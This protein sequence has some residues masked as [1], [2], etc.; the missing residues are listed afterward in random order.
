M[1]VVD[2]ALKNYGISPSVA[3]P[4]NALRNALLQ[5]LETE[6][7]KPVPNEE[8]IEAIEGAL[9]N[10]VEITEENAENVLAQ[11]QELYIQ[12]I[13]SFDELEVLVHPFFVEDF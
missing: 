7:N 3:Y 8:D 9:E 11:Y 10:V 1:S 5:E 6:I 2:R 4:A 13:L 12:G